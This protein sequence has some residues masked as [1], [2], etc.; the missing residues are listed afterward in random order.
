MCVIGLDVGGGWW[1][2]PISQ[3]VVQYHTPEMAFS[4]DLLGSILG[5]LVKFWG[6]TAFVP[7]HKGI[8][9]CV[10]ENNVS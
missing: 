6:R 9:I 1:V 8:L 10:Q 2:P 4:F 3:F 5:Y 7:W